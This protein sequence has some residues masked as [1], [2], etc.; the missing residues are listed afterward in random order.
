M[1][2]KQMNDFLRIAN[3]KVRKYYPFKRQR[4]AIVAKMYSR[5]L[6]RKSMIDR[7]KNKASNNTDGYKFIYWEQ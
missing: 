5:W 2:D 7:S 1:D 3:A 4:D 6:E